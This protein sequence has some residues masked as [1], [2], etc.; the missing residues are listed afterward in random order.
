[1]QG[2]GLQKAQMIP[3]QIRFVNDGIWF[4]DRPRLSR[5]NYGR[6]V[7]IKGGYPRIRT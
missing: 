4:I 7:R 6:I 1:M 2:Q 3:R 5:Y